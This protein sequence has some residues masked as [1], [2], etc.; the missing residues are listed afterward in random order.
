MMRK[1]KKPLLP[2]HIAALIEFCQARLHGLFQERKER[3][4]TNGDV[5]KEI[6]KDTFEAY[7]K[8]W[9]TRQSEEDKQ[10]SVSPYAV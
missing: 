1:D 3:K 6:S 7:Y 2:E 5:L 9:Q 8:V 10:N 4:I